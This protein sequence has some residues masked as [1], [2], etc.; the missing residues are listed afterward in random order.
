MV[1]NRTRLTELTIRALPPGYFWDLSLPAFGIRVGKRRR[2]FIVVR[3]GRRKTL[4][5]NTFLPLK[6]ARRQAQLALLGPF[7]PKE[8]APRTHEAIE[9]NLRS[10]TARPRT[11]KAYDRLLSRHLKAHA[12]KRLSAITKAHIIAISDGLART[13]NE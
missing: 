13:P 3:N 5:L 9:T 7:A 10:L 1:Q 4:G 2:A 11:E 12:N 8:D 6:E